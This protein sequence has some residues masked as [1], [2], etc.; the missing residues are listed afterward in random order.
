MK[1]EYQIRSL[2]QNE[3][4]QVISFA[5]AE[6]W[7][8]GH[9]D[10]QLFYKLA[11][12]DF[13]GGFFEGKL[14]STIS[15]INYGEMG[16]IGL[17]IVKPEY[18][19]MGFGLKLFEAALQHLKHCSVIGLDAVIKQIPNYK[20]H[21]FVS[22][23]TQNLLIGYVPYQPN[24]AVSTEFTFDEVY[25][26][27][28]QSFPCTRKEFYATWLNYT[29]TAVYRDEGR[30]KGIG[31][32]RLGDNEIGK[33]GPLIAEN[34]EIAKILI[35]HLSHYVSSHQVSICCSSENVMAMKLYESLN[36]KNTLLSERMYRG[37]KPS[38]DLQHI[39]GS[40]SQELG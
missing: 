26:L 36:F 29:K 23:Y 10:H 40:A 18:R 15:C 38:H 20:K 34:A 31:S 37:P 5:R 4:S 25:P 11:E 24:K 1:A 2:D 32:I 19:A 33:I 16:F 3:F 22:A 9:D 8:M 39:F 12:K 17:Y 6:K 21:G 13:L 28:N 14:V 27:F 7:L 30:V 35:Q